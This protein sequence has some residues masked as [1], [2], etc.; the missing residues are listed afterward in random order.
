MGYGSIFW[1]NSTES[2]RNFS[3]RKENNQ[4]YDWI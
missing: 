2:E 3:G 4:N 1:G